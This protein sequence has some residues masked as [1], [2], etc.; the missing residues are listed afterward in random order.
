MPNEHHEKLISYVKKY[1]ELGWI[2]IP[3]KGKRPII[4]DWDGFVESEPSLETQLEK[5]EQ[6]KG[7]VTGIGV[8]TGYVYSSAVL[9]L[10]SNE[11][12]SKHD[13]PSCPTVISGGGGRHYY[14]N[15]PDEFEFDDTSTSLRKFG[16]EGDLILNKAYIVAPPSIH[17]DTGEEYKWL[18]QPT[19][20]DLPPMPNW[21]IN[22]Y[23]SNKTTTGKVDWSGVKIETVNQGA[24]H[25]T[26]LSYAGKLVSHVP[27][28]DWE[29]FVLPSLLSW[30][31]GA[32]NPPMDTEEV[33]SIYNSVCKMQRAGKTRTDTKTSVLKPTSVMRTLSIKELYALSEN[34]KPLFVIDKLLPENGISYMFGAP[35][36]G[37]SMVMLEMARAVASGSLFLNKFTTRQKNTLIVDE[38]NGDYE[39]K[40][41]ASL[42]GI[43]DDLPLHFN[44]LN[45]FKFDDEQCVINLMKLC[46]E[47]EIGMVIFDPFVSMHTAEE[48]SA[49]EMQ[50]VMEVMQQFNVAGMT[51]LF[52]H[53]SRK[54]GF[55]SGA[56]NSRGS[57]AIHGR[58]DS[59]LTVEKTTRGQDEL[60]NIRHTKSRRGKASEPLQIVLSQT[61]EEGP[62]Q[63]TYGEDIGE[64]TV[65]KDQAKEV[66]LDVLKESSVTRKNLIDVVKGVTKIGDRNVIS[67]IKELEQEHRISFVMNGREKEYSLEALLIEI[68]D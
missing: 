33:V 28:K 2:S 66:I 62:I 26:A 59:T 51:V 37:K 53:H 54:G 5:F 27:E 49:T 32:C 20:D 39:L 45:G 16:I 22:L 55:G 47:K 34:E 19:Y 8:V 4:S 13:I 18:T 57:S 35:G 58:A 14:L 63:M 3:L 25:N 21:L 17:P 50:R 12:F 68:E 43:G 60:I 31:Q 40:R 52:I 10:E 64:V 46:K 30:N 6:L 42:L 61:D 29:D 7:S 15:Y 1:N 38:E 24:R 65:K 56:Q 36:C 48:N 41:R 23:K 11:D 9:D 67:A 44:P